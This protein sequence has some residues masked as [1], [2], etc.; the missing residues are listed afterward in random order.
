MYSNAPYTGKML[1]DEQIVQ[2]YWDRNEQAIRETDLKYGQYLLTV[3]YNL[4][5]DQQDCEE[6]QNDTYLGAWNAIPPNRPD[7]FQTFLTKILRRIAIDRYKQKC[8]QKR[9]SSELTVSLDEFG[10]LLRDDQ[11]S[12]EDAAVASEL[13][14]IISDFLRTQ[15]E[16]RRTVFV[17]RY[18]YADSVERIAEMLGVGPRAIYKEL[19]AL[20]DEL[21][22]RLIQEGYE[23]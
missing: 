20:R 23:L 22:N 9:V 4:L 6:C 5:H 12:V 15:T 8:R 13:A 21:K 11:A 19:A 7:F 17:F 18:Y 10:D 1:P 14:R 3:A 16:R 2:M